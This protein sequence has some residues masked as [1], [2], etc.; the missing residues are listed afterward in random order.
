M[1]L[2]QR[3][4]PPSV[5]SELPQCPWCGGRMLLARI[6]PYESDWD[7]RTFECNW[8]GHSDLKIVAIGS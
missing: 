7:Q 8:C 3:N 1:S 5:I 4:L 2:S 6:E